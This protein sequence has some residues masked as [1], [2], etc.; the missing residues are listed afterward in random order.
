MQSEY[1]ITK[2]AQ[3]MKKLVLIAA[4]AAIFLLAACQSPQEAQDADKDQE[5]KPAE[6]TQAV[7]EDND[8]INEKDDAKEAQEDEQQFP[9]TWYDFSGEEPMLDDSGD[10]DTNDIKNVYAANDDYYIYAAFEVETDD[11]DCTTMIQGL[12]TCVFI[13]IDEPGF[14]SVADTDKNNYADNEGNGDYYGQAAYKYENGMLQIRIPL[15]IYDGAAEFKINTLFR[16]NTEGSK[17]E[18][19]AVDDFVYTINS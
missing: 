15:D 13:G 8:E 10:A 12:G 7:A 4:L 14:F 5:N 2:G 17:T 9:D 19:D 18:A 1:Y 11:L 16:E 3:K 6:T